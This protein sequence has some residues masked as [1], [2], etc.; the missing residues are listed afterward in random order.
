MVA[1]SPPLMAKLM[2]LFSTFTLLVLAASVFEVM[3]RSNFLPSSTTFSFGVS[4]S[5]ISKASSA[6]VSLPASALVTA[7]LPVSR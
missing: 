7:M 3:V 6:S 5:V 2:V 1:V 4:V